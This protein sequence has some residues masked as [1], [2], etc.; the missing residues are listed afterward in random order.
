MEILNKKL[1]TE[2]A[3]KVN[4]EDIRTTLDT[5]VKSNQKRVDDLASN[6]RRINECLPR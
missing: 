3:E 2:Y 5:Q 1:V 4:V 6:M